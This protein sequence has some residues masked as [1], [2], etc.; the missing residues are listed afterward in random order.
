MIVN[1]V[2]QRATID[3]LYHV[4]EPAELINGVIVRDMTGERPGEVAANIYVSLRSHAKAIKRGKAYSD[5]VGYTVPLMPSGR[6]SFC[7]DTSYHTLPPS[8]NPMRFVNGAPDFGVEV[9]SQN[10]YGDAAEHRLADKRSDY[11]AAG[12]QVVWDV[13]P[14]NE[15]VRCYRSITP[16]TPVIYRRG[17]IADAEPAVPGW[18]IAVDEIFA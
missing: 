13:D 3:D 15:I 16:T 12:T 9:R 2:Q 5:G 11:F 8:S 17:D 4:E 10:D 18:R 1:A 6:E 14:V 7:P